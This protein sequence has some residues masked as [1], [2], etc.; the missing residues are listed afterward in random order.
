MKANAGRGP[1]DDIGAGG[2]TKSFRQELDARRFTVVDEDWAGGVPAQY[3]VAPRVRIGRSRWFNLLWLVPIGFALALIL[4]A[5]AQGLRQMP[6]IEAFIKTYPGKSELPANAPVGFPAWL[7]WQHF[8]NLFFMIFIIRAGV[9]ILADHP[10]LYWTRHSTPG[11]DWFRIQKPVPSDPL[12]TAKQDSITLPNG[13]GLP[14][15][16]HSIGLARWWHLGVDTLW[17]ANGIVFYVLLFTTGQ[18]MRLVPLH[19]DVIPNAIAVAI[20]YASLNWPLEAGWTDYNSLQLIAYFVTV[21]IAAPLALITGLG[22]SPALSTR[23]RR[24]SSVFSIQVARSL[25][26]L[27]LCWFIFFI[28]VH[29]T[30]VLT[31]GVLRNLNHMFAA[32]NDDSWVGFWIFAAAMIVLIAC[33]VAATPFTYRHPRIVQRVGFALIGPAQRLFEHVDSKPGQYT[34]KDISRYFWHNGNYPDMEDFSKLQANDFASYRLRISGLVENP[35]T[36]TLADLRALP[37]HEQITQHFCIQGW[38]GVAKWGGVSMQTILDLVKPKPEAKWVVFYSY[39]LGPEG[40]LYY[41]AQAIEQMS[42][43]LTMLAY[44]MNGEPVSFGHGAPLRL[45]N[46]TQLGFKMVKWIK[47][48][49]F[50]E[51][52][53][54]VGGGL[55]GYNNDH[56]FFG[57]RQSI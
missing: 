9:T 56:E 14:G 30:L 57:Y 39:A 53:S 54:E 4:I 42:Y 2:S 12:Y 44:D 31:T 21:F 27:V 41:D 8:L 29:V 18:W 37:Y 6:E 50:V 26:F 1:A 20:Q 17:L 52:F 22:M 32:R 36:L 15:R 10:R 23:F 33:W 7:A 16:R 13:V 5:V 55:G 28:V 24:I 49:E 51:H 46:E 47:G 48:I 38:S 34:D 43:K 35:V 45:R 11:K 3:G 40:G 19:W 25:H